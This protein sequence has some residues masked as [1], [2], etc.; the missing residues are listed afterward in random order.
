[1]ILEKRNFGDASKLIIIIIII[2]SINKEHGCGNLDRQRV[3]TKCPKCHKPCDIV[4][5]TF[6]HVT[7]DI[8]LNSSR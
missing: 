3:I 8:S 7:C 4:T 2:S 1:M 6:G 5:L